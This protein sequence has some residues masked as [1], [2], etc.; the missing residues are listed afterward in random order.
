MVL[1]VVAATV[2]MTIL[3]LKNRSA[4]SN[5]GG[6]TSAQASWKATSSGPIEAEDESLTSIS[7]A[8]DDAASR[9]R[10]VI[11]YLSVRISERSLFSDQQTPQYRAAKWIADQ[12][13]LQVPVPADP[14]N[15]D[16]DFEFVQRYIMAVFYFALD[17]A[18]W[19]YKAR[20]MSRAKVCTWNV[21]FLEEVPGQDAAGDWLYGVQCDGKGAIT[22]IFMSTYQHIVVHVAF[23]SN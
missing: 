1:G 19:R 3:A 14:Q 6:G 23:L 20:F 21:D 17:G 5:E 13:F 4:R 9:L 16:Q 10:P 15:Y 2:C 22:T 18:Q 12:D 7:Q 11:D 8:R